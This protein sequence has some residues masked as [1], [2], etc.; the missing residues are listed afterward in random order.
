M[1]GLEEN[2]IKSVDLSFK[3]IYTLGL[4][5]FIRPERDKSII[6][7]AEKL[8]VTQTSLSNILSLERLSLAEKNIIEKIDENYLNDFIRLKSLELKDTELEIIEKLQNMFEVQKIF[9]K[10]QNLVELDLSENYITRVCDEAL[11][12][13]KN[14]VLLSL[15][16]NSIEKIS[17]KT[18]LGLVNLEYLDL[19]Q[20][21]LKNLN[22]SSFNGL[23]KLIELDLSNNKIENISETAFRGL[24]LLEELNLSGNK[25]TKIETIFCQLEELQTLDLS[26]NQIKRL[27]DETFIDLKSLVK[28]EISQ[29]N[30]ESISAKTFF[31]L[32]NL[33]YLDL[34]Q[35]NLTDLTEL[36]K[37]DL[38]QLTTMN[39]SDNKLENISKNAFQNYTQLQ[40][41]VLSG[42]KLGKISNIFYKLQ[43]LERLY[44]SRNNI[45]NIE[46]E[47][48]IDLKNLKN[49]LLSQNKLEKISTNL[50]AGLVNLEW[51]NL[52]QNNLTELTESSLNT[53]V[54]LNTLDLRGNK[55]VS[56]SETSLTNLIKL[57]SLNLS[58]NKL[59]KIQNIFSNLQELKKLYLSNNQIKTIDDKAF[60]Y[61]GSLKDLELQSNKI[62]HLQ[63]DIFKGTQQLI[64]IDFSGNHIQ[65][66]DTDVF[67]GLFYLDHFNINENSI[68]SISSNLCADWVNI[69][70]INL[71]FNKITTLHSN[72]FS[73]LK[74]LK[75]I[76]LKD[77]KIDT[78]EP[79]AFW[80]LPSLE[81][82]D[83]SYNRIKDIKTHAFGDFKL[84]K[85]LKEINLKENYEIKYID[86][87]TLMYIMK[88]DLTNAKDLK[89]IKAKNVDFFPGGFN[90]ITKEIANL[91]VQFFYSINFSK[92]FAYGLLLRCGLFTDELYKSDNYK[93]KLKKYFRTFKEEDTF[94][95]FSQI[96]PLE[97]DQVFR[98]RITLYVRDY[99]SRKVTPDIVYESL[100][101]GESD[102]FPILN[103][104]KINFEKNMLIN[105]LKRS[106]YGKFE[107]LIKR[108]LILCKEPIKSNAYY[109][110]LN[111]ILWTGEENG[112]IFD[113][114]L[115]SNID[116]EQK[117]NKRYLI[118]ILFELNEIYCEDFLTNE[119]LD[120][121]ERIHTTLKKCEHDL[122]KTLLYSKDSSKRLLILKT[123]SLKSSE[124]LNFLLKDKS[125]LKY[126]TQ[127]NSEENDDETQI[128]KIIQDTNGIPNNIV[129]TILDKYFKLPVRIRIP[130]K[131]CDKSIERLAIRNDYYLFK[132]IFDDYGHFGDKFREIVGIFKTNLKISL[133]NCIAKAI[134][135]DNKR[136]VE[137]LLDNIIKYNINDLENEIIKYETLSKLFKMRWWTEIEK[138]FNSFI[139]ITKPNLD[140]VQLV[141]QNSEDQSIIDQANENPFRIAIDANY[142]E[143]NSFL[144]E[145]N[146]KRNKNAMN[147]KFSNSKPKKSPRNIE[148]SIIEMTTDKPSNKQNETFNFICIENEESIE[149]RLQEE[150]ILMMIAKSGQPK[151]IKHRLILRLLEKKWRYLPRA[152]YHVHSLMHV[153]FLIFF[154]IYILGIRI[155]SM[156]DHE[157]IDESTI[158]NV[159]NS[160][161]HARNCRTKNLT[162]IST[163][164]LLLYFLVYELFEALTKKIGYFFSLKNWIECITYIFTLIS[165]FTSQYEQFSQITSF[166]SSFSVLFGFMVIVLR[167]EKTSHFGAYVVACRR[168]FTKSIKTIP[169]ILF[170]FFGFL[171]AL[172]IR[173]DNGVTI[174]TNSTNYIF[175]YLGLAKS[176]A[177][178]IGQ[179]ELDNLGL[180][181]TEFYNNSTN[182]FIYTLFLILMTIISANLLTG[183]AIGE[184]ELVLKEAELYNIQQK[185]SYILRIQET[186][187]YL[188]SKARTV[189]RCCNK[190]N[191]VNKCMIFEKD[192]ENNE[193]TSKN[194]QN[195]AK[196]LCYL[197]IQMFDWFHKNSQKEIEFLEKD[198]K[199]MTDYFNEADYNARVSRDFI[200]NKLSEHDYKLIEI[201]DSLDT[202]RA[203]QIKKINDIDLNLAK[204]SK[205]STEIASSLEDVV[206]KNNEIAKTL[207]IICSEQIKNINSL[208]FNLNKQLQELAKKNGDLENKMNQ[209]ND[210]MIKVLGQLEQ[211]SKKN[212]D[213]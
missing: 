199:D 30:I 144:G 130:L 57:Q 31:G 98:E 138:V 117:Y 43:E 132:I 97:K 129:K 166:L 10:L 5:S 71:E 90:K 122:F 175:D 13:F 32:E 101:K 165:L 137:L 34:S 157:A 193:N 70:T 39:L 78:I 118:E 125:Q 68:V 191:L 107:N 15:N 106:E 169:L 206:K 119:Y 200:S 54:K 45:T 64:S 153:L 76:R 99:L 51:L 63:K 159:T 192:E 41:L 12:D 186:L 24:H 143:S 50:F 197:C 105:Y 176:S 94:D 84:M 4:I 104:F 8:K 18:F 56:I 42:N 44:L 23:N 127:R 60:E 66:L 204:T 33:N 6:L 17:E 164:V 123:V 80:D 83:L 203:E 174:L 88:L 185:I 62:E 171:F 102:I 116:H 19:S 146:H 173:T 145:K 111:C 103:E 86:I 160:T 20:N 190:L 161:N 211:I 201:S 53:L 85:S 1:N 40:S 89:K 184:L 208:D 163:L 167:F 82:I 46:D 113:C 47:A 188:E 81:K 172:K 198:E 14:L 213:T 58:V 189:F 38:N 52:S 95:G 210:H 194:S 131:L 35:N 100:M 9:D 158:L 152:L 92:F 69:L 96:F 27:K 29:N 150:H 142:S 139:T 110:L 49:L 25:L 7:D 135:N 168:S 212:S 3:E 55:I 28:L 108:F 151:L 121:S 179:Y 11:I 209:I 155:S 36:S 22:E 133:N 87:V 77:N 187:F 156:N 180:E 178:I 148:P 48:F 195:F 109:I 170:L 124:I 2:E 136:I 207:E 128:E 65:K 93:E 16:V 74:N 115:D 147:Y 182:F 79:K 202:H 75:V 181:N 141:I 162:W 73:S 37:N 61:L 126:L 72:L 134:E 205:Q 140:K 154:L 67:K 114:I 112:T 177:M 59:T 196:Y 26:S 21:S 91:L 120:I 149:E 183:I